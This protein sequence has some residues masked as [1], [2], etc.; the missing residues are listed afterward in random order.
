[1]HRTPHPCSQATLTCPT[2]MNPWCGLSPPTF[3]TLPCMPAPTD[4]PQ[5]VLSSPA[6]HQ[7]VLAVPPHIS[8]CHHMSRCPTT[9]VSPHHYASCCPTGLHHT[10]CTAVHPSLAPSCIPV[11]SYT[12]QLLLTCSSLHQ[13][14]PT[15]FHISP[16]PPRPPTV[17]PRPMPI[18]FPTPSCR[19]TAPSHLCL[20]PMHPGPLLHVPAPS[21]C[22]AP[23]PHVL[24]PTHVSHVPLTSPHPHPQVPAPAHT[25]YV[26]H[27]LY[28]LPRPHHADVPPTMLTSHQPC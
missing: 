7:C 23:L 6:P 1:M 20:V 17:V 15:H 26:P 24:A 12:S 8:A 10:S 11:S 16:D 5:H 14:I 27:T 9:H 25:W 3:P 18:Y 19:S 2:S 4:P 22:R 21:T 13:C 28:M